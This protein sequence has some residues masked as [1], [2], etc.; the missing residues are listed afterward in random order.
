MLLLIFLPEGGVLLLLLPPLFLRVL[1]GLARSDPEL[2][3]FTAAEALTDSGG[4]TLGVEEVKMVEEEE[5]EDDGDSRTRGG[6]PSPPL[7]LSPSQ[8]SAE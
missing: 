3:E 8:F 5:A 2:L 4:E 7:S 6:P 1:L